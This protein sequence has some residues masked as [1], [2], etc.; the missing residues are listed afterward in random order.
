MLN[1]QS[2][3]EREQAFGGAQLTQDISRTFA[4][5]FE[6]AEA[7]KRAMDL[8]ENYTRDVLQPF[9][10]NVALE[11]T[12]ALQ[13]FFTSTPYGRVDQIMLGGGCSVIDGLAD[14]VANRS[15]TPTSI[16][17]PFKGMEIDA[18]IREKQLRMDAPGLLTCTGLAMRRFVE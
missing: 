18:D 16:I 10:E 5:P 11:V 14:V 6:E 1:G 4:L 13:F 9:I 3:Y 7:K 12:R 15:Q 8:P 2:I 17:N